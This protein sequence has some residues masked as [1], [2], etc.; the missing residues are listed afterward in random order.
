MFLEEDNSFFSFVAQLRDEEALDAVQEASALLDFLLSVVVR[1]KEKLAAV[2]HHYDSVADG[3]SRALLEFRDLRTLV[4]LFDRQ[5]CGAAGR[6]RVPGPAA[7]GFVDAAA[8]L[9]RA[10]GW[11]RRDVDRV[12]Y[13]TPQDLPA[14]G[15]ISA[16]LSPPV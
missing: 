16:T 6:V 4:R 8:A 14:L 7:R 11:E 13:F 10:R 2:G 9:M 1:G 15:A 5:P 12:R 3:R